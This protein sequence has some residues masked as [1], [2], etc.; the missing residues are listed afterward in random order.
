VNERKKVHHIAKAGEMGVLR[1]FSPIHTP[2][3][4]TTTINAYI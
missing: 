1:V 3:L 2:L 4:L